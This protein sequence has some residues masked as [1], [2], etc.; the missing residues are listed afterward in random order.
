M[1][2]EPT[3]NNLSDSRKYL[4]AILIGI[5]LPLIL[6]EFIFRILPVSDS[7]IMLPINEENPVIRREANR[8]FTWSIGKDFS[9]VVTKHSNNYGFLNDQD[10]IK[11]ET[12]PLMA[13]IGDSY[14]Q[15]NQVEN[16][17]TMHGLLAK[18]VGE[19]GRVYSFGADRSQLSTYL[20]YAEY[21][22]D[23]FKPDSMVFI[24]VSNDFDESLYK[25]T[26]EPGFHYFFE[27]DDGLELRK[28]DY[29][30]SLTIRLARKSALLRYMHINAHVNLR[31]L[32]NPTYRYVDETTPGVV[33][34]KRVLDSKKVVDEF[35]L[36]LPVRSNLTPEDILFVVDGQRLV[37]YDG[38]E[39]GGGLFGIMREYF[40]TKAVEEGYEVIDMQPI[41]LKQYKENGVKFN[42]EQDYHWNALGH[43]L[44][45]EEIAASALFSKTFNR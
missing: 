5:F 14:V 31:R 42:F 16:S 1:I 8:D 34:E 45:A 23:E 18:Q 37:I 20:A 43:R 32:L 6:L 30:P 27:T 28:V 33:P 7:I 36:Q 17:L 26:Q 13:I 4:I 19:R 39:P 9:V 40:I 24:V 3:K 22:R 38:R 41:F 2:R 11:D 25:Y 29:E 21:T 35:F 12:S 44:V 10:Y 15:A